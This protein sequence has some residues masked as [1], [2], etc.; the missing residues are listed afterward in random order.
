MDNLNDDMYFQSVIDLTINLSKALENPIFGIKSLTSEHIYIS[1]YLINLWKIDLSNGGDISIW[2][3]YSLL[4][5][6]QD[7]REIIKFR[8]PRSFLTFSKVGEETLPILFI[9]TPIINP[10]T[11]NVIGLLYQGY[12]YS[13]FDIQSHINKMFSDQPNMNEIS[14]HNKIKLTNRQKQVIYFLWQAWEARK[15]PIT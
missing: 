3:N 2:P 7:D 1:P 11:N 13:H 4:S 14:K 12:E 5:T 6:Y 9:K 8:K 10:S 15:L